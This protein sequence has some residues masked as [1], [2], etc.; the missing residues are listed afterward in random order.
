MFRNPDGTFNKDFLF[1]IF[2]AIEVS[3]LPLIIASKILL[4]VWAMSI[5]VGAI[6]LA[7]LG[8]LIL[9]NPADNMHLY[10][11]E[12]GAT[13]VIVF[14]LITYACYGYINVALAVVT[15]CV[16]A[17]EQ[18]AK[19]YFYFKPNSQVVDALNFAVEMFVFLMLCAL[20][21]V[22]YNTTVVTI[23]LISL[24]IS[25]CALVAVQGYKFVY[26]YIIKGDK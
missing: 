9:K 6:V 4:P 8:M 7:K 26:Y 10:L 5:F 25:S 19:V 12:G 23:A 17:L 14:T 15:A 3:F 20:F 13:V 11:D 22:E 16:F 24:L 18:L 21:F 2:F 1:K